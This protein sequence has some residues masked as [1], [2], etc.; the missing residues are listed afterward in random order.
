LQ[1]KARAMN[2][3][4]CGGDIT[5]V[6]DTRKHDDSIVARR[7]ICRDCKK[8]FSTIE[9]IGKVRVKSDKKIT[10]EISS[11]YESI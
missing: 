4:E 10:A 7:R 2:C 11:F 9:L 5:H 6:Y 1:Q 8:R 3:P